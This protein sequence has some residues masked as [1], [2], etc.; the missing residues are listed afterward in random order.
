MELSISILVLMLAVIGIIL[1]K[2]ILKNPSP[3]ISDTNGK[4]I[5][6]WGKGCILFFLI[7]LYFFVLDTT[8]EDTMKWFFLI[9]FVVGAVFHISMEWW[10]LK[11]TNQFVISIFLLVIGLIYFRI[12]IF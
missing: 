8:E 3:K 9:V 5:N 6:R 2:Y 11:G 12:V 1:E 10:Y 4:N 7:Y